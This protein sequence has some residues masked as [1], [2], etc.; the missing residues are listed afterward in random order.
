VRLPQSGLSTSQA[1]DGISAACKSGFLRPCSVFKVL[2]YYTRYL[3]KYKIYYVTTFILQFITRQTRLKLG[4]SADHGSH[5]AIRKCSIYIHPLEWRYRL[6]KFPIA[7]I[8][9]N[10][11]RT[12]L[13]VINDIRIHRIPH[14]KPNILRGT[15]NFSIF[16]LVC[17]Y[18]CQRNN[19]ECNKDKHA[20]SSQILF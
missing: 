14:T 5:L 20:N 6:N 1:D 10:I 19:N 15:S 18:Y 16:I 4:D 13:W 2:L 7:P 3:W 9:P 8:A 17:S 12:L 11:V